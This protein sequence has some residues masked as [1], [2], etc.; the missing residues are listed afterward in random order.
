MLTPAPFLDPRGM[1]KNGLMQL[2]GGPLDG[3]SWSIHVPFNNNEMRDKHGGC[4]VYANQREWAF[5]WMPDE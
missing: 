5:V 3:E 1:P 2:I 4:Y